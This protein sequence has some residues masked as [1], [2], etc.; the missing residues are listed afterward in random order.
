MKKEDKKGDFFFNIF[1]ISIASSDRTS[2]ATTYV[3]FFGEK[4]P[5]D[6]ATHICISVFHALHFVVS[7]YQKILKV[8]LPL[9]LA[10]SPFSLHTHTYTHTHIFLSRRRSRLRTMKSRPRFLMRRTIT[11]HVMP[12]EKARDSTAI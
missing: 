11:Q 7:Q 8:P 9:S 1:F 6:S 12:S 2:S 10:L 5:K 4:G 3:T